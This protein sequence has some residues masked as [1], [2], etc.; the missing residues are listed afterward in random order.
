MHVAHAVIAIF[1]FTMLGRVANAADGNSRI[2][3]IG[4][5]ITYGFGLQNR[6]RECYPAKLAAALGNECSVDNF[7]SNGATIIQRG[8]RPYA[9]EEVFSSAIEFQ[10]TTA[11][12]LLGT[13]DTNP[14]TWPEHSEDFVADY[15]ALIAAF[16]QEHPSVQVYVC[17]PPPLFRDRGKEYD[18]DAILSKQVLPK[19]RRV[20]EA[21]NA[22]VIDLNASMQ[23][24]AISFPDG[25]HPDETGAAQIATIV[26][27][28]LTTPKSN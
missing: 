7:G 6:E 3:C 19:I 2:A 21:A 25:V 23:N 13:N 17:L 18:T 16:R 1:V 27:A 9:R 8:T 20:A 10:P 14:L 5:S 24:A 4:D 26:A 22:K 11:I 28:A 15:L 12:I